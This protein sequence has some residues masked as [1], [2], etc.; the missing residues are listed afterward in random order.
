MPVSPDLLITPSRLATFAKEL[1]NHTLAVN[2]G[3]LARG[4]GGGTY[5]SLTI[6]PLPLED[7]KPQ[8]RIEHKVAKR[9]SVEIRR[10]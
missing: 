8:Q 9:T 2:P 1:G 3:Q 4:T 10:I 7:Q 6:N 5:A